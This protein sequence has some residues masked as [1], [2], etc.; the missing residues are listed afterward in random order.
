[1]S[2]LEIAQQLGIVVDTVYSHE[3]GCYKLLNVHS[4]DDAVTL[5][6]LADQYLQD[7]LPAPPL[8]AYRKAPSSAPKKAARSPRKLPKSP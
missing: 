7:V 6:V 2:N 4:R 3:K 8:A 5:A 1:M